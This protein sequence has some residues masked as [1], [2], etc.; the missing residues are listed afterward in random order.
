MVVLYADFADHP[1]FDLECVIILSVP[2]SQPKKNRKSCVLT[3]S[4]R[5]KLND[6]LDR[7]FPEGY[8]ATELA[9]ESGIH[10]D[11]ISKILDKPQEPIIHKN[12]DS[13]FSLLKI[14]LDETDWENPPKTKAP[15]RPQN[16]TS[17]S[18]TTDCEKLKN[19]LM[20]LNYRKQ[21]ILF[22]EAISHVKPAA[23]FLIHGKPNYGQSWLLNLLK[24]KLPYHMNALPN[25]VKI[26]PNRKD[27]QT[28]WESLAHQLGTSAS[29][30]A[31]RK[32]YYQHLQ[33][34]TVILTI[35]EVG[36]IAKTCLKQFLDEL[37]QPLV[38]EVNKKDFPQQRPYRLV[39]F[40]VDNQNS[41]SKLNASVS[42]LRELD[43]NQPYIP[44]A[45]EELEPFNRDLIVDWVGVKFELLSQLWKGSKS[46]E[47]M[48]QV[49][50]EME[51]VMQEI[52]TE[53]SEPISVFT[54]ICQC[55]DLDWERLNRG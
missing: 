2:E 23:T 13:L 10:R 29:P 6:A 1:H 16:Q 50:Q 47:S 11:T 54:K 36:R 42:L 52:V 46:S 22:D 18:L 34:T 15:P 27:I 53:N 37:W 55:M 45:L 24:D 44:L 51:Q 39:L 14:D 41:I 17:T 26:A 12:L 32:Q 48:E 21:K 33:T 30:E 43:K 19:A 20:E 4:G 9:G 25:L 8:N 7:K 35:Y 38:E 28:I 3:E 49:M 31:I 40:L 5:K